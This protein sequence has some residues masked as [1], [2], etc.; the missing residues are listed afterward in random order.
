MLT[1]IYINS[2]IYNNNNNNKREC[3]ESKCKSGKISW[4]GHGRKS[5]ARFAQLCSR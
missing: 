5:S 3:K 2:Y 1:Y 4:R